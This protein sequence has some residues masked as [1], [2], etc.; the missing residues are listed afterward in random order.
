MTAATTSSSDDKPIHEADVVVVGGGVAGL[1]LVNL[2][3]R[4]GHS[5]VL[6]EAGALGGA[7]TL[8]S[9]GLIHGGLKYALSG[10]LTR[11]S[12]AIA[13]MP[14]R[15]RACLEGRGEVDLRTL[16]PL[17]DR[18][19]MFAEASTLGRLTT[20]FASRSLRG[21][22]RRLDPGQW[23]PAFTAPGFAGVVYALED[24]VLDTSALV[25]A[26]R[27]PVAGCLY[28]HRVDADA[29]RPGPAGIE[30]ALPGAR[31]SARRLVL[32]AGAGTQPL[33]EGL[34][35]GTPRMQLRPLHQVMVRHDYPHP[36][37]AHCLT[38]I[39]RPEPRLTITSHRD[40][41]G[42]IWYLG[43]QLASDGVAMAAEELK[44]HARRE[45]DA[46]LPW[47]DWE[48]AE[49]ATVRVD[50]AEPAQGGGTRPDEAFAV[51]EGNCVVAWPT[52]LSLVPDLGDRVLA[53]L[54]PPRGGSAPALPLPPAAAGAPPWSR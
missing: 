32:A 51:A 14:R 7:Q 53:L 49:L 11:A 48:R 24:F 46:C 47:I 31:L 6:L 4:R 25:E 10:N 8:A 54:P 35:I 17:S 29:L 12:E 20:F 39:R 19:Y 21:R 13:D 33:L 42:W 50:R 44:V 15:W 18:Y 38:G 40:G 34:G 5:V 26:L 52:K 43:G 30:I 23:P 28:R 1:W 41:D 9:Q 3:A 45:L 2:L 16:T 36:V 22:I 37:F 27:A